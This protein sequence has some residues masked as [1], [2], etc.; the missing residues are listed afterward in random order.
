MAEM[1]NVKRRQV[2][3]VAGHKSREKTIIVR[4]EDKEESSIADFILEIKR[5]LAKE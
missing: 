3:L 5:S 1:L 2:E 4:V